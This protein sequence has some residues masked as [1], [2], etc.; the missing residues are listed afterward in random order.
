MRRA[1][2]GGAVGGWLGLWLELTTAAWLRSFRWRFP[3]HRLEARYLNL[4]CISFGWHV[5]LWSSAVCVCVGAFSTRL[6]EHYKTLSSLRSLCFYLEA[7][8]SEIPQFRQMMCGKEIESVE[9]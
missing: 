6:G 1:L 4:K 2:G 3:R 5:F 8:K 7:D 9:N